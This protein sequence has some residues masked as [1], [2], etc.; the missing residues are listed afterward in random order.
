[1]TCL[2]R[3]FETRKKTTAAS[4]F[5]CKTIV[6]GHRYVVLRK[7]KAK[8]KGKKRLHTL[9]VVSSIFMVDICVG[10]F[11]LCGCR[12]ALFSLIPR[13]VKDIMLRCFK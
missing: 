6:L 12:L 1:M 5:G 2:Q 4:M 13:Y 3:D 9:P 11:A 7:G 10:H 8:E